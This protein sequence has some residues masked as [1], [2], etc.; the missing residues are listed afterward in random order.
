MSAAE[1]NE[2]RL[3]GRLRP[4]TAGSFRAFVYMWQWPRFRFPLLPAEFEIP[5]AWWTEPGMTRLERVMTRHLVPLAALF[6]EAHPQPPVLHVDVVDPHCERGPDPRERKH[7]QRDQRDQRVV[8]QPGQR[9]HIDAVEQLPCLG[10][11]EHRR[12][13]LF[14]GVTGAAHRR[15]RVVRH[16]LAGHEPVEEMTNGGQVLFD[17]RCRQRLRLQLDLGGHVQR[18]HRRD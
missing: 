16:D 2:R 12:L 14:R 5:D 10:G 7:H 17:G 9:R 18:L 3:W 13:A 1:K 11:I 4:V 15:G 8:A 6:T